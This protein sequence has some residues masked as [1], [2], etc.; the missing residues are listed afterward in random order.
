MVAL[1]FDGWDLVAEPPPTKREFRAVAVGQGNYIIASDA[2]AGVLEGAS[3]A[4][5]PG[6]DPAIVGVLMWEGQVAAVISVAAR[7]GLVSS[8]AGKTASKCLIQIEVASEIFFLE[9]D[10]VTE[11]VVPGVPEHATDPVPFVSG[12]LASGVDRFAVL[13]LDALTRFDT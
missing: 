13:D 2:I 3:P 5:V 6:S 8:S 7:L 11:K 10:E 9:V 1:M 4:A 12:F